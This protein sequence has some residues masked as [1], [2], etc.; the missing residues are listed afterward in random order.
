MVRSPAHS[1]RSDFAR[2]IAHKFGHGP[3]LVVSPE[4]T[5]LERQFEEAGV[6]ARVFTSVAELMAAVPQ[7]G[8]STPGDL[9]I[10]FYPPEKSQDEH[11]VKEIAERAREILLVSSAGASTPTLTTTSRP[12]NLLE[13]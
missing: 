10:W 1:L 8:S 7:N 5:E 3:F 11:A 6:K 13:S 4:R 2:F 9:M 12:L